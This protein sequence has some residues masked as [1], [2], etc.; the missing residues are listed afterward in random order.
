MC[1]IKKRLKKVKEE[2]F[3]EYATIMQQAQRMQKDIMNKK[4][5]LDAMTFTG[6]SEWVEVT[7]KGDKDIQSVNII[8]DNA[9]DKENREILSDMILIAVKDALK[10]I[11]KETENKLGKYSNMG[12]LF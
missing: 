3:Y 11:D 4:S 2:Y 9:F 12:G 8:N 6:K 7:F 5:E 10:Q 1:S